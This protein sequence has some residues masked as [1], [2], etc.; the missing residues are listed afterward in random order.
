MATYN[1]QDAV[2]F[3]KWAIAAMFAASLVTANLTAS[4]LAVYDFPVIGEVTG[5]V[6]AFM[7]GV[8][9]LLTDIAS[10]VYGR[11][12]ARYIV[13]ASILSVALAFGLV[14]VALAIPASPAYENAAAFQTVLG[15][16][17]PIL[18][19]SVLS[20]LLS[21]NVDVSVFHAVRSRT[22]SR[23]KWLRNLASTGL[24]QLLDTAVFT[25]LAFAAIPPLFNQSPLPLG[26]I[27]GIIFAEYIIKLGFALGDTVIFYAVTAA[28]SRAG[29]I[30]L[31]SD[32]AGYQQND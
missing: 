21:Q 27:A 1:V 22:G 20:L 18:I 5:S 30:P 16:S 4:K 17:Y 26:V 9:F 28:A 29:A 31:E 6:A 25:W 8:S 24:S 3:G 15:A 14:A 12:T 11:R 2:S 19:A 32:D 23:H 10:E 13:N 7:I